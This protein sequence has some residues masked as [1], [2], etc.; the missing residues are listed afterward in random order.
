MWTQHIENGGPA[1]LLAG[2]TN[3]PASSFTVLTLEAM[4]DNF[5]YLISCP[6]TK[7]AA[8]VDPVEPAKCVAAARDA[9]LSIVAALTTHHHFD[10]AGGNKELLSLVP[11]V[12]IFGGDASIH[13]GGHRRAK[14]NYGGELLGILAR[15][16]GLFA[17]STFVECAEGCTCCLEARTTLIFL[18]P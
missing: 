5:M 7:C 9:G 3:A 8:V 11:A 15:E 10:H 16:M 13:I 18:F 14:T 17:P 4:S 1:S 12:Q 6:V 2:P